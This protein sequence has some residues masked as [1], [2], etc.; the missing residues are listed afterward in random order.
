MTSTLV[1]VLPLHTGSRPPAPLLQPC[2]L[3]VVLTPAARKVRHKLFAGQQADDSPAENGGLSAPFDEADFSDP[4][5]S[6]PNG[7]APAPYNNASGVRLPVLQPCLKLCAVPSARHTHHQSLQRHGTA[8]VGM[9]PHVGTIAAEHADG[10]QV[11]QCTASAP[12]VSAQFAPPE[13]EPEAVAA[14]K[15]HL[16]TRMREQE[17]HEVSSKK[18]GEDDARKFLDVSVVAPRPCMSLSEAHELECRQWEQSFAAAIV[19][20]N[21]WQAHYL[22]MKVSEHCINPAGFRHSSAVGVGVPPCHS[23]ACCVER[24]G[25]VVAE[26]TAFPFGTGVLREAHVD[27]ER[28]HQGAPRGAQAAGRPEAGG[29]ERVGARHQV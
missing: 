11:K 20:N 14:M 26:R 18:Q 23:E 17:E 27:E 22:P 13:E 9:P 16:R 10:S 8:A 4:S 28:Q 29:Q 24:G 5:A 3:L 2:E 12:Q 25:K 7:I 19:S 15:E 6:A 21:V 1:F